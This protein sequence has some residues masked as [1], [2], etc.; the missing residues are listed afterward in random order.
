MVNPSGAPESYAKTIDL[1][2]KINRANTLAY[3]TYS[4]G[5]NFKIFKI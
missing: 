1:P 4:S 5:T 3:L 2:E